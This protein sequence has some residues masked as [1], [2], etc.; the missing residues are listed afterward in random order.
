MSKVVFDM[1]T[2]KIISLF[3][4][5]THASVKDCI[6]DDNELVFIV[7]PGELGKA[8][9]KAGANVKRLSSALKRKIK[10]VEFSDQLFTFIKNLIQPLRVANV[11]ESEGVV[12]LTP[13]DITTRG[14]LIGRGG[15]AL[16]L[17]EERVKRH[18]PIKE[19]KVTQT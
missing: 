3:Q 7:G 13:P 2:M 10:I 11:E 5:I 15:S 19:I 16:R 6:S 18:F 1:D 8:I 17:L 14:Y 9:G 12:T 4:A